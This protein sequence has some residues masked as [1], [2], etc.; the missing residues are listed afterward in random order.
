MKN[1]NTKH[2]VQSANRQIL[3]RTVALMGVCGIFIFIV[4]AAR[5][6]VLQITEHELYEQEAVDQQVRETTLTASRGTI[7]DKNGTVLAMSASVESV[8]ISPN[9]IAAGEKS[10]ELIAAGLSEILDVDYDA[11]LEKTKDSSSYYQTIRTKIEKELA[12][13]VRAFS[14]ENDLAGCIYLE[15]ATKRYYPYSSVASHII[16]FVG[17]DNTGLMGIESKYD[18]YLTGT[19]GRIVRLKSS[20]GTDMLFED[21]EDYY[22]AINGD[23]IYL[24]IDANIQQI[25]EKCLQQAVEDYVI[26]N[27]AAAVAMNPKTGEI[28]GMVTLGDFDLNNYGK[29]PEE[30]LAQLKEKHAG[31]EAAYNEAVVTALNELWKN[32]ITNFTYEPGSTFKPIT[33]S[34]ALEEG[35][36]SLNSTYYCGGSVPVAGRDPVNCWKTAGHGSQTLT[37]AL[38]HSCN[39]A[40]VNIGLGVGP[41][42][43]YDYVK[44][45]GFIQKTGIDLAGE[46]IGL[47]WNDWDTYAASGNLTSLAAA[48][49]GQTFRITPIQLVTAIS[50]VVNGGYLMEPYVVDKAVGTD[51]TVSYS[52]EPTVVRQVISEETSAA[53]RQILE[54]VVMDET[55]GTGKNASVAGYRIGGKT[56]TSTDTNKE[57]STGVKEYI[58]SFVGAAPIDDPQIVLLVLLDNPSN[59]SGI[60]VSGGQMAAPTVGNML[61]D[62]LP[63]MGIKP[64]YDDADQMQVNVTVPYARNNSVA[65]AMESLE[66]EGF[67]VQVVGGGETVTDQLPAAGATVVKGTRIILYAGVEKDSD[68]VAV[69]DL[70]G[71]TYSAAKAT[72]EDHGLFIR[73]TGVGLNGNYITV[74]SQSVAAGETVTRGSVIE[75]TLLDQSASM[76]G[77][78]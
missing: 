32:R 42:I 45:F 1:R 43:F 69:P 76:L 36:V 54:A 30:T 49:F 33:W 78:F 28:L 75:V 9:A 25:M 71:M 4:L 58:V 23:N 40:A 41:D 34:M 56:G 60:Y 8:Y 63:Y 57:A 21:Y 6:Y 77:L 50:A 52:A 16:G 47:W 11:V 74:T 13:Q 14:Q 27:G 2:H 15:P 61:A 19:N 12:D 68:S 55:E 26:Q 67:V 62:I 53:M 72:L 51:G 65:E 44:A 35:V 17:T 31:D 64:V 59:E 18:A 7:Y 3:R 29:L 38:Q 39:V 10:P 37:Q 70:S 66:A 73:S 22:D 24:T 46:E 48:S 5:L 20:N